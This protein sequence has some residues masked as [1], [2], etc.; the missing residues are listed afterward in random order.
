MLL[1]KARPSPRQIWAVKDT[2][3]LETY[4]CKTC[5]AYW[6]NIEGSSFRTSTLRLRSRGSYFTVGT[7][8]PKITCTGIIDFL[9]DSCA[10]L[11]TA[12]SWTRKCS[13]KRA[14]PRP[15]NFFVFDAFAIWAPW[16]L[17]KR[18]PHGDCSIVIGIGSAWFRMISI[19]S[20]ISWTTAVTLGTRM[21]I[22]RAGWRLLSGIEA[23]YT[24][25]GLWEWHRNILSEW[26]NAIS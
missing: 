20:G 24:G 18:Q 8:R 3:F 1:Q 2:I 5:V 17:W 26:L 4:A 21:S 16:W 12:T 9:K 15:Q 14:S 23:T 25:S 13:S 7:R 11:L 10:A 6:A 19:G 22:F